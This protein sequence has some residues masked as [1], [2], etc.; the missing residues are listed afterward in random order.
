MGQERLRL[1]PPD[2]Q[3][4]NTDKRL[5]HTGTLVNA[6]MSTNN[7]PLHLCN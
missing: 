6:L 3:I 5:D 4:L 7:T 1:T 2:H